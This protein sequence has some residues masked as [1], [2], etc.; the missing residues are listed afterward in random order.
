MAQGDPRGEHQGKL[1]EL[2]IATHLAIIVLGRSK[3][4]LIELKLD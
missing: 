3:E 2:S 4:E 1:Q